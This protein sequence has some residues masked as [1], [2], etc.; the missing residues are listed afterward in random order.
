[1]ILKSV[2]T[3]NGTIVCVSE[4]QAREIF[5]ASEEDIATARRETQL[6]AIRAERNRRIAAC[7]WTQL[8]DA[9]LASEQKN[10]WASYR[11]AL[12][13]LP[14]AAADLDNVVWPV[15]PA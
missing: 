6:D 12:R 15:Q 2:K 8:P 13:D 1:M 7:D 14:E 11:Q 3:P 4:H 10:A 9:A 5:G